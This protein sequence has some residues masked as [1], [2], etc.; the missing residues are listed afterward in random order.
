MII[1]LD[2]REQRPLKFT[3]ET[4]RKCLKF[5]D[6]G[7]LFSETH[8]HPVVFERKSIADLYGS[9]TF[10]YD[11]LRKCFDRAEKAK[12]Q[13]VIAIEGTKEKVLEG[14]KHSS[15]EPKSIIKQLETIQ[16]KYN[17]VHKFFKNRQEMSSLIYDFYSWHYKEYLYAKAV[18]NS[19]EKIED[20]KTPK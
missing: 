16:I 2:T 11:R 7:A 17:V 14:Y 9:L 18:E 19:S 8:Q 3:C 13:L 4:K 15:R 5:G 20:G 12:F 10:G 6:Y 1:L